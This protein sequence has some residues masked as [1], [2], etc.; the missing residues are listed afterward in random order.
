[1]DLAR[2]TREPALVA[3]VALLSVAPLAGARPFPWYAWP[4]IAA[5]C[6]PL[7]G[8]RTHPFAAGLL[9]GAVTA[10]HSVSPVPEPILPWASLV[11]L[12][13]IAVHAPRARARAALAI[14]LAVVPAVMLLDPQRPSAEGFIASEVVYAA[15]WLLGERSALLRRQAVL[16]EQR[17]VADERARMAR[18]M[19]DVVGHQVSLVIVQAEAGPALLARSP[20]AAVRAFDAISEA[21]RQVLTELRQLV[22]ALRE[23]PSGVEGLPGLLAGVRAA[24]VPVEHT[25][26]GT[27]E[28]LPAAVDRAVFRIVQEALT[29]VLKHASGPASVSLTYLPATVRVGVRNAG[30][31]RAAGAGNGIV[32]MRERVAALRGRFAAGP[33]GDGWLVEAELPR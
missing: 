18:E 19:H 11:A 16:L 3:L 22:G 13:S 14:A 31:F 12:Y 15:A 30:S 6:L 32:G 33:D 10:V 8:R 5:E 1:M 7:L 24:G 26:T 9:I 4:L 17:A 2:R 25:V 23:T 29:N 27:V 28:P 21:G 20:E